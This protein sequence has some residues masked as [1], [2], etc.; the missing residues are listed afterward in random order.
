MHCVVITMYNEAIELLTEYETKNDV[1]M[2]EK[3]YSSRVIY[4]DE[5][6]VNQNEFFKCREAGIRPAA[7]LCVPYGE[8]NGEE[9]LRWNG[10]IYKVYRFR[11]GFHST[12]LYCEVRGG[13]NGC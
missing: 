12:E 10:L 3:T 4:A 13:S 1:G 8:Y 6:P 9:L 11:K 7:C 2:V 5:L